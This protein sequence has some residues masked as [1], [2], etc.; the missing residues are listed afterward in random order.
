MSVDLH[1]K[2]AASP[3]VPYRIGGLS[4]HAVDETEV[5][6]RG[7]IQRRFAGIWVTD[8]LI[9]TSDFR[10]GAPDSCNLPGYANVETGLCGSP[11]CHGECMS[12]GCNGSNPI[13]TASGNKFQREIDYVGPGNQPIVFER[14]YNSR[15]LAAAGLGTTWRHTYSRALLILDTGDANAFVKAFRHDGRV[16][17]FGF[18]SGVWR[19]DADVAERLVQSG[20]NW[21]LTNQPT[22]TCRSTWGEPDLHG[23]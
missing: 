19:A 18:V 6:C 21:V 1:A 5:F 12:P 11:K 2:R 10:I 23:G 7:D 14:Y 8:E 15:D 22:N 4:I 9:A 20:A 16:I 17:R 3:S 13:N